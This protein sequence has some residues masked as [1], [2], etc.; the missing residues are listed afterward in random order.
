MDRITIVS[1]RYCDVEACFEFID[2]FFT[3][4]GI[5]LYLKKMTGKDIGIIQS[6][7]GKV[8]FSRYERER[9]FMY[10][11]VKQ[12]KF[13][14]EEDIAFRNLYKNQKFS[15]FNKDIRGHDGNSLYID[16]LIS[17]FERDELTEKFECFEEFLKNIQDLK[18]CMDR[19]FKIRMNGKIPNY[20]YEKKSKRINK[21]TPKRLNKTVKKLRMKI[22]FQMPKAILLYIGEI[23][24][25][26]VD[27]EMTPLD[28]VG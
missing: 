23:E 9:F 8:L 10:A 2:S 16:S 13:K 26:P 17:F 24:E 12:E 25:E 1:K 27:F 20:M 11:L 6:Y 14:I 7:I 21:K 19:K 22:K 18:D 28:Q 3:G 15:D 5:N 4:E